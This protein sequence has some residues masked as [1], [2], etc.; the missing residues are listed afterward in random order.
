MCEHWP[1]QRGSRTLSTASCCTSFWES[2]LVTIQELCHL[3]PANAYGACSS[4]HTRIRRYKMTLWFGTLTRNTTKIRCAPCSLL[5]TAVCIHLY[6]SHSLMLTQESNKKASFSRSCAA[7]P[8]EKVWP[9]AQTTPGWSQH[10]GRAALCQILL[11][12]QNRRWQEDSKEDWPLHGKS[13]YIWSHMIHLMSSH[14]VWLCLPTW[15]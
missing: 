2:R 5:A 1:I 8:G 15:E 10:V 13:T 9:V 6:I 3:T 11:F 7:F 4:G 14:N 12:H